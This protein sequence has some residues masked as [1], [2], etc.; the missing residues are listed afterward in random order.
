[1][2]ATYEIKHWIKQGRWQIR[3][4][5]VALRYGPGKLS[6]MPDLS[7]RLTKMHRPDHKSILVLQNPQGKV[8]LRSGVSNQYLLINLKY[9]FPG[10]ILANL[11]SRE[12]M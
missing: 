5:V 2:Q 1:M 11:L 7:V 4:A 12:E 6:R 3:R 8:S 10:T 9:Q